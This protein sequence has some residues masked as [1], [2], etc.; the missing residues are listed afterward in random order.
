[1]GDKV[2]FNLGNVSGI[3]RN[4]SGA[5]ASILSGDSSRHKFSVHKQH[6]NASMSQ[7]TKNSQS[8]SKQ[9]HFLVQ[10]QEADK[11]PA[12]PHHRSSGLAPSA[13][14]KQK[15]EASVRSVKVNLE[16]KDQVIQKHAGSANKLKEEMKAKVEK[17]LDRKEKTPHDKNT[18]DS[19]RRD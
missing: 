9:K 19:R 7:G 5:K 1:M 6:S 17:G 12:A 3:K 13:T 16:R 2:T 15:E 18:D 14:S 10:R 4:D 11:N 8:N